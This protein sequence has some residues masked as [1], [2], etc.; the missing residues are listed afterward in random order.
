MDAISVLLSSVKCGRCESVLTQRLNEDGI[1]KYKCNCSLKVR[2][3]LICTNCRK[4]FLNFPYLIRRTN[5]CSLNCYW[6]GTDR[7]QLKRCKSCGKEF[8]ADAVLIKKGYGF[9]CNRDCWFTIFKGWKR[10]VKCR[11]C[12]K[13]FLVIRAVYKKKPKF[14]S[15]ECSDESKRN[16][17][18][19]SC[20]FC[21]K[22]FEITRSDINRGRGSFCTWQCFK[23][24]QG[25]SSL[26]LIVRQ[27][28]E[29]LREPFQQEM[30]IGK[31]R[32]DFYLPK[33]NLV[34]ECDGEY[35]HMAQKA[36]LRDQRKDK[37]L[38]KLGY[39]ILRLRGQD[40]INNNATLIIGVIIASG[41]NSNRDNFG[42][43][44]RQKNLIKL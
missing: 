16:S 22:E 43:Y 21:K 27:Q 3:V 34:I 4:Q 12:K 39:N 17:V 40:I 30:R 15:K 28:L 38:E 7:R 11:Q 8:Y 29:Q 23:K 1:V 19:R 5:Y 26:E 41:I 36:K 33:K 9:Y 10:Q 24:Y 20:K 32:M 2:T 31:F 35:W 6:T 18:F 25:E 42:S 37:V 14:C 13:T 44:I